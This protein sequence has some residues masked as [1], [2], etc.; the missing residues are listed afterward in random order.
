MLYSFVMKL[1]TILFG[2]SLVFPVNSIAKNSESERS[3]QNVSLSL[4]VQ[5]YGPNQGLNLGGYLSLYLSTNTILDFEYM[6]GGPVYTTL[7]YE[8]INVSINSYGA[9]IRRFLGNSFYV[10]L[11]GGIKTASYVYQKED[12]V[13]RIRTERGRFNGTANY[14]M[15]SLGN[16]WNLGAFTI[17]CDWIGFS[18]TQSSQIQEV[19]PAT[20]SASDVSHIKNAEEQYLKLG[21]PIVTRF[22]LGFGF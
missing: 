20:A 15:I 5:G 6:L 12:P 14:L 19:I 2:L 16:Q 9:S 10:R 7:L 11:G 13:T 8:T 1:F 3:N 21:V 22:Y 17:G 18:T 4:N